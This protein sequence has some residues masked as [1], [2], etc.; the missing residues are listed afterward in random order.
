[1]EY[2]RRLKEATIHG[3]PF[4]RVMTRNCPNCGRWIYQSDIE[5]AISNFDCICGYT[6]AS[7]FVI[8][9]MV[10]AVAICVK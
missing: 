9:R 8:H 10:N 6:R 3:K 5:E 2:N 7:D 1:M 4:M